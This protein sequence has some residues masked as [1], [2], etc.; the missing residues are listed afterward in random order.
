[1]LV[2]PNGDYWHE[3]P[4]HRDPHEGAWRQVSLHHPGESIA[5]LAF[6]DVT[7]AVSDILPPE[8]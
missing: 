3:H 6:P 4:E 7:I 8:A 1:M 5:M 2:I